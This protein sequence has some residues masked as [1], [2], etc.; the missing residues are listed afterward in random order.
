MLGC[1]D[2]TGFLGD[3]NPEKKAKEELKEA[4][5]KE[6][7][8]KEDARLKAL[9]E[10]NTFNKD[11]SKI[12]VD[13]NELPIGD[14]IYKELSVI[15]GKP[16][17]LSKN[18]KFESR[19]GEIDTANW[20][21]SNSAKKYIQTT[22]V[23]DSF[24]IEEEGYYE[25]CESIFNKKGEQTSKRT[26]KRVLVEHDINRDIIDLN[27]TVK[28]LGKYTSPNKTLIVT[29]PFTLNTDV[30]YKITK[31][32]PSE[33]NLIKKEDKKILFS[34]YTKG[35]YKICYNKTK[36]QN[37]CEIYEIK[38]NKGV[39]YK[40]IDKY[41][42]TAEK[43]TDKTITLDI[44]NNSF[45]ID[46]G[47]AASI[48][49]TYFNVNNNLS[50]KTNEDTSLDIKLNAYG[51][52]KVCGELSYNN[53]KYFCKNILNT[54]PSNLVTYKIS[55]KKENLDP[56]KF[57]MDDTISINDG[58]VFDNKS[59][60]DL[61]VYL[62]SK[63]DIFDIKNKIEMNNQIEFK[64]TKVVYFENKE[65]AVNEFKFKT[66]GVYSVVYSIY[67]D[68]ELIKEGLYYINV[69][70]VVDNNIETVD[71]NNG[72]S[73]GV[74]NVGP[75]EN[76]TIDKVVKQ[77]ESISI[78]NLFIKY[79]YHGETPIFNNNSFKSEASEII[80]QD[81]TNFY[82][83]KSNTYKTCFRFY[84][85]YIY[86]GLTPTVEKCLNIKVMPNDIPVATII[87]PPNFN[88]ATNQEIDFSGDLSQPNIDKYEWTL[89]NSN[90]KLGKR[91]KY[92][93][94]D[95]G[96]HS[97]CLVVYSNSVKSEKNCVSFNVTEDSK[98]KRTLTPIPKVSVEASPYNEGKRYRFDCSQSNDRDLLVDN[99]TTKKTYC[100]YN[101]RFYKNNE[102]KKIVKSYIQKSSFIADQWIEINPNTGLEETV[103]GVKEVNTLESSRYDV[104]L[105][106]DIYD[107]YIDLTYLDDEGEMATISKFIKK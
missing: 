76:E 21:L 96:K 106:D 57:Q 6:D 5:L 9:L 17:S 62:E 12:K 74:L 30:K 107:I 23:I 47:L 95:V 72:S 34:I 87:A 94:K 48:D 65:Y 29:T 45:K 19:L 18:I 66:P 43:I 35:Y 59:N 28:V 75:V 102:L 91:V 78:I 88:I 15:Q 1:G 20:D 90:Q 63:N 67:N 104:F 49:S 103:S 37:I 101:I 44:R 46:S 54:I 13:L 39:F 36:N 55:A 81:Q 73:L 97:V 33:L 86:Q 7:K 42:L 89:D 26:C 14:K 25:V 84:N 70:E 79:N 60:N 52:Y 61:F 100:Y 4:K 83:E 22:E 31:K 68:N 64:E 41:N 58:V 24:I 82:F 105:D 50:L 40:E 80:L 8:V 99:Y 77:G 85:S 2:G 98:R 53:S 27:L 3:E 69:K 51:F 11:G 93:F 92:V 38:R 56:N 71:F 10:S 32:M 16:F